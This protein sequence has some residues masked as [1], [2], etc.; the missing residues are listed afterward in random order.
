ML[1]IY[2][3]KKANSSGDQEVT[4]RTNVSVLS[5]DNPIT[6]AWTEDMMDQFAEGKTLQPENVSYIINQA[7]ALLRQEKN[8]NYFTVGENSRLTIVGD[9]HGQVT[10]IYIYIYIM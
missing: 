3:A 10:Y 5:K 7:E 1:Y 8:I 4:E 6:L 2:R 9:L